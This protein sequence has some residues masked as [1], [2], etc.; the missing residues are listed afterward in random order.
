MA[1]RAAAEE[2]ERK[3]KATHRS[4]QVRRTLPYPC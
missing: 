3:R 4:D 2:E 1:E